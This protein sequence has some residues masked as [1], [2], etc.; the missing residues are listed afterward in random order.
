MSV[1]QIYQETVKPL[2]APE[3]LQLVTLILTDFPVEAVVDY[4]EE[5]S[6]EDLRDATRYSLSRAAASFGEGEDDAF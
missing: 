3:R 6:E 5:W 2:S 4:S 1:S